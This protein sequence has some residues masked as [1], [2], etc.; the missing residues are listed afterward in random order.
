MEKEFSKFKVT[1]TDKTVV[2]GEGNI[3]N[4]E[5]KELKRQGFTEEDAVKMY[6]REF[7][8]WE[9]SFSLAKPVEFMC[10]L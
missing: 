1:V 9:D 2:T 10:E 5:L 6:V 4:K 8:D 7:H 3:S